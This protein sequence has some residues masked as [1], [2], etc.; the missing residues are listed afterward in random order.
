[1]FRKRQQVHLKCNSSIRDRSK[2]D[3]DNNNKNNTHTHTVMSGRQD[4][5]LRDLKASSSAEYC[6][7]NTQVSGLYWATGND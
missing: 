6:R 1:M 5:Y 2:N 3:D 4:D 7:M